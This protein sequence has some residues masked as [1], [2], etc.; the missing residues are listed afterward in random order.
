MIFAAIIG[1]FANICYMS[2][3]QNVLAPKMARK[4][5]ELRYLYPAGEEEVTDLADRLDDVEV[6]N[7]GDLPLPSA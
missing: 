4:P 7:G 5:A 6:L 3:Y 2:D 1:L